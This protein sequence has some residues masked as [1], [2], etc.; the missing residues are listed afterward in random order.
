M[1][2]PP[3]ALEREGC[4]PPRAPCF[5]RAGN[6]WSV[7]DGVA[8]TSSI[9]LQE[10]PLRHGASW[11][12]APPAAPLGAALH[13]PLNG[14]VPLPCIAKRLWI[15]IR[16]VIGKSV[17]DSESIQLYPLPL[18]D[19]CP[20][21]KFTIHE[22]FMTRFMTPRMNMKVSCSF[23]GAYRHVFLNKSASMM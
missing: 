16:R 20:F 13:A 23:L 7:L 11:R 10:E 3:I 8:A 19:P 5:A 15:M 22:C 17:T 9:M 4:G 12:V 21:C 2:P 1:H 14:F 18:C 6:S